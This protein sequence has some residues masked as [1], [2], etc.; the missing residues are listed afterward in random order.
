MV[1]SGLVDKPYVS[2]YRLAIHFIFAL[3][4]LIYFIWLTLNQAFRQDSDEALSPA[5]DPS[6]EG[7]GEGKSTLILIN[8]FSALQVF[9]GALVAGLK[10]GLGFNTFPLMNGSWFPLEYLKESL[11]SRHW[12]FFFLENP[13]GVQF[14]HRLF[15]CI[16]LIL[17][18]LFW[19][20]SL[21]WALHPWQRKSING[22]G[23]IAYLQFMLGVLTLVRFVPLK[24][25]SAHQLLATLLIAI[26][27]LVN[28]ALKDHLNSRK[29]SCNALAVGRRSASCK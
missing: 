4:L 13:A 12:I 28:F 23:I 19:Y 7:V 11:N 10:A 24:L 8:I 17:I 2:H 18:S 6:L 16:L 14:T 22:L 20:K 26:L 3:C 1:K 5:L 15:A 25:A 27:T 21:R 9:W 29:T